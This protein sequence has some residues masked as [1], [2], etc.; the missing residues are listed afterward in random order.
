DYYSIYDWNFFGQGFLYDSW[1][2]FYG[3]GTE[4]L[5]NLLLQVFHEY[6]GRM[7]PDEGLEM[8]SELNPAGGDFVYIHILDPHTPYQPPQRHLPENDYQGRYRVDS[9]DFIKHADDLTDRDLAQLKLLYEGEVR[10]VDEYLGKALDI[11]EEGE[12]WQNTA[13][14]FL[15]DHGEEFREHGRLMHKTVNLHHELTHVP[16]VIY[17]PGLLEGG[18]VVSEPVSLADIYPTVLDALN[19]KYIEDKLNARSLLTQLPENRPIFAQRCWN[20]PPGAMNSDFVI[21]GE[22]ALF[23]NH[24]EDMVELYLSYY[25]RP[26]NQAK[27]RPEIVAELEKLLEEWHVRNEELI[28]YHDTIKQQASPDQ[29]HMENLRALGYLQ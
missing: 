4:V 29:V 26:V 21:L 22:A 23:V 9:L 28:E 7:C 17:W 11:L 16:L 1:S 5:C 13:F 14:I 6:V 2:S 27:D 10:Y 19:L 25:D 8:L 12:L 24:D 18:G 20:D 3:K 15:S